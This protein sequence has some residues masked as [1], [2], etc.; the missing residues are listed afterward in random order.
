MGLKS[1]GT[2]CQLALTCCL[3][4]QAFLRYAHRQLIL[5]TS[6]LLPRRRAYQTSKLL[7]TRWSLGDRHL[8]YTSLSFLLKRPTNSLSVGA[9]FRRHVI[10]TPENHHHCNSLHP[11]SHYIMP[12]IELFLRPVRTTRNGHSTTN[13]GANILKLRNFKC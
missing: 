6:F 3:V 7:S 12:D 5:R 8:T 4:P 2:G 13:Y 11:P 1:A 10:R 9:N